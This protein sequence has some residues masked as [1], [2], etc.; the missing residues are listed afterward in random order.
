MTTDTDPA[1]TDLKERINSAL[2]CP[3]ATSTEM[4]R[5]N[6]WVV[7]GMMADIDPERDL[8]PG[9]LLALLAIL[10]PVHSNVLARRAGLAAA[11]R[12]SSV[13]RL[14]PLSVVRVDR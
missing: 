10:A 7:R 14:T 1:L 9:E 8:S 4:A 12:L 13:E 5:H 6:L 2:D 3:L 11:D